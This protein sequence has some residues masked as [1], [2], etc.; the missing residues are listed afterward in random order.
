M[1]A[2]EC[3]Y[4]CVRAFCGHE[5][6]HIAFFLDTECVLGRIGA[7]Y[8]PRLRCF[9]SHGVGSPVGRSAAKGICLEN[10]RACATPPTASR[11]A[12][13]SNSRGWLRFSKH[14]PSPLRLAQSG[15]NGGNDGKAR[16]NFYRDRILAS[17]SVLS[18]PVTGRKWP[19]FCRDRTAAGRR[20]LSRQRLRVMLCVACPSA[21]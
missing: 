2:T 8:G 11:R 21:F 1:P 18:R 9:A 19:F 20:I 3:V 6:G 16:V 14:I 17:R 10:R 5:S 4:S 15:D 13:P 12:P 7:F